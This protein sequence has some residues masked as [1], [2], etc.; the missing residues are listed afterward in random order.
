MLINGLTHLY[1]SGDPQQSTNL[2]LLIVGIGFLFLSVQWFVIALLMTLASWFVLAWLTFPAS[3]FQHFGFAVLSATVLSVL[4][5]TVRLKTFRRLETL[6]L[7]DERR[8]AKLEEA[9]A[10]AERARHAAEVATSDLQRSIKHLQ[11]SEERFRRFTNFEGIAVHKNGIVLDAN[12]ALARMFGYELKEILGKSIIDLVTPESRQEAFTQYLQ[13]P[14]KPYLLVGLRKDSSTFPVEIY[15]QSVTYEGRQVRVAEIR[16]IT[17]RKMAEVVQADLNSQLQ[18]ERQRLADILASVP[19]VVWEAWGEPD[20]SSQR[21]DFVSSYVE[22]MLGYSVEEWLETPNFWLTIVHPED[23]Q[24][25]ADEAAAIFKSGKGGQSTFRW[26]AKDGRAVWVEAQSVVVCDEM[27]RPVGMRGVTMDITER[28]QAEEER[29]ELLKREQAARQ[30][31]ETANRFKDE[32]LATVSHEL[33][34]PL[35]AML[36]WATILRKRQLSSTDIQRGIETIER[37]AKLQSQIINDLLDVSRIIADK[38]RL[39]IC[40]TDMVKVINDAVE[41]VRPSAEAKQIEL[42]TKIPSD[43]SKV[44]GDADRLQQVLWNL[45]SN[46]VKFTPPSGKIWLRA[47]SKGSQI[48]ITVS[49][50]G[51]GIGQEFLPYVFERFRQEDA[52]TTRRHGGLGLGLAI[53]QYIVEQHGGTVN[54]ESSGADQGSTFTVLL[55]AMSGEGA[56]VCDDEFTVS[57]ESNDKSE[58]LR[59]NEVRLLI[60]DDEPDAIEALSFILKGYGAEVM[61]ATSSAEGLEKLKSQRPTIIIA[62]IGMPIEDGYDFIIKAR[63]QGCYVPAIALTA[64]ARDEDRTR[65][66]E[67]GYQRHIAKPVEPSEIVTVVL[68]MMTRH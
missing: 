38:L 1:L 47:I 36:G 12:P 50:T 65:A 31:A 63:A 67:T 61:T 52:S 22:K 57:F 10:E 32:F 34:T 2:L 29:S 56:E 40:P 42:H 53:V 23:Q 41:T 59:L 60:V 17:E 37:N 4:V 64:F 16:D 45:L 58:E 46:A 26:V 21:I 24:R 54:A 5:Q 35:N 39:E 20:A 51:Q 48:E 30:N 19:G 55:P 8:A 25:A 27:N 66:L 9:L 43:L 62:D 18:R 7:L 13:E 15:G 33:R 44:N 11:E 6:R 28:K 3:D 14:E 49:D 68:E